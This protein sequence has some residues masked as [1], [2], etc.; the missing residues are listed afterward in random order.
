MEAP[1]STYRGPSLE[2][3]FVRTHFQN[4]TSSSKCQNLQGPV[5]EWF[6]RIGQYIADGFIC[7]LWI[8]AIRETV[9]LDRN[10]V[11][12]M[13]VLKVLLQLLLFVDK[14]RDSSVSIVLGYG[15]DD[16]GLI[17]SRCWEFFSKLSHPERLWGPP[18]LLS[19]GGKAAGAWSWPLTSV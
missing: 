13:W 18:S 16:W 12:S 8:S 14:S 9:Q 17:P 15:L 19:N 2:M 6:I 4:C 10:T 11:L 3:Q 1:F 5:N 7:T